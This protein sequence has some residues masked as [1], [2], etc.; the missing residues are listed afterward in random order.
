MPKAMGSGR[1]EDHIANYSSWLI[2]ANIFHRPT[3]SRTN[4]VFGKGF[5]FSA[6]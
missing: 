3:E 6:S 1:V 2:K 4:L 5:V